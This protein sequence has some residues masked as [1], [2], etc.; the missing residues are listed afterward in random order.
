MPEEFFLIS[1]L[2]GRKEFALSDDIRTCPGSVAMEKIVE[3][4]KNLD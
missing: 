3:L 4:K 2:G 1:E